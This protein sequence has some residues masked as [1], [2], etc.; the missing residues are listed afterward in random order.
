MLARVVVVLVG[1]LLLMACTSDGSAPTDESVGGDDAS[2]T[3]S[4]ASDGTTG[5][6]KYFEG[7]FDEWVALR[8]DC[9]RE[10]GWDAIAD[11]GGTS[12]PSVTAEQREEFIG[13]LDR[14][15]EEIG[16]LPPPEPLT[17]EQIRLVYAHQLV[18]KECLEAE[19]YEISEPP[20]VERFIDTYDT[21]PWHAYDDLPSGMSRTEWER[22][23]DVCP[24]TPDGL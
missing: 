12:V 19:G 14:C 5:E 24:Q 22:L 23:N 17:E 6:V 7:E 4:V 9:L 1:A 3:D 11:E 2:S 21:E 13:D 18:T 8:V 10:F 16:A 20:S 15:T